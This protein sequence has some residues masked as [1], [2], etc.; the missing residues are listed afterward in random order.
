MPNS[1]GSSVPFAKIRIFGAHAALNVPVS[2]L[3][4]F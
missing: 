2:L 4:F 1:P 3:P